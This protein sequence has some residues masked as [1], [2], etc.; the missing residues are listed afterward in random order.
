MIN[1][2]MQDIIFKGYSAVLNEWLYGSLLYDEELDK[3][4]ICTDTYHSSPR[5]LLQC[6]I[7]EVHPASVGQY[8]GLKDKEG[9]SIYTGDIVEIDSYNV[10]LNDIDEYKISS[11]TTK[12]I[13]KYIR[14]ECR[15]VYE[16]LDGGNILT[17]DFELPE[18]VGS[19]GVKVVGNIFNKE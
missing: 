10:E 1:N 7:E 8:I 14:P 3:Y 4:F 6:V 16:F 13:V 9:T 17:G 15:Y 19:T 18:D 2:M 12:A 11:T 5:I